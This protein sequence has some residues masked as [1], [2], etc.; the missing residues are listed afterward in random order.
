MKEL[1]SEESSRYLGILQELKS[2]CRFYDVHVHPYEVLFDRFFYG[3][4]ISAPG[5][6]NVP[7]R[8]YTA[9]ALS[10][11]RFTDPAESAEFTETQR[12]QDVWV[13][14]LRKVYGSVGGRVFTDQMNLSG[15]DK[16]L[17]L[18]VPLDSCSLQEFDS[19]MRWVKEF[20]GNE[21]KFWIAGSIPPFLVEEDIGVYLAAMA[22]RYGIKALKCHPVISGIDLGESARKRW[23]EALL[24]CCDELKLPLILHGGRNNP[25][26][27]GARGNF[28][29]LEHFEEVLLPRSDTPVILAHAGL[30][31]CSVQEITREALPLLTRMLRK[32]SNLYIDISGL[33]FEPLKLVLR[34]VDRDRV[35]FGSDAL[36]IQQWEAVAL[37][38]HALKELGDQVGDAFIKIASTNPEKTV[39]GY[40]ESHAELSENTMEP[41][42]G[43]GQGEVATG[44]FPESDRLLRA[45]EQD[46]GAGVPGFVGTETAEPE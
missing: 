1:T 46:S 31:R 44:S 2:S 22:Q 40:G 13:M 37:T 21:D 4:E 7:G 11:I 27:R 14:L 5:L 8:C 39:F 24:V 15:I 43:I 38:M 29:A 20:Y 45:V 3:S 30:H 41:V 36:Y 18:P 6:L 33:A 23:L 9:P 25:Y 35:I 12:F 32:N 10:R 19:R 16:V 28:G 34:S 26:W 17:M 42:Y